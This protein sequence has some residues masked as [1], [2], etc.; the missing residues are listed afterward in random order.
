MGKPQGP[1]DI[2]GRVNVGIF[3]LQE[4][5]GVDG[6]AGRLPESSSPKPVRLAAR[7]TATSTESKEIPNILAIKFGDQDFFAV[8]DHELLGAMIDQHRHALGT[9]A[10]GDQSGNF[11]VFA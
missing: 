7:P 3:G 11:R 2:A 9:E 4:F 5:V 10:F 6:F 1:G 8:F